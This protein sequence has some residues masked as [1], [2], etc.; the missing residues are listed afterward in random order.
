MVRSTRLTNYPRCVDFYRFRIVPGEKSP[1]KVTGSGYNSFSAPLDLVEASSPEYLVEFFQGLTIADI[2]IANG[3]P[4]L[5]DNPERTLEVKLELAEVMPQL[6]FFDGQFYSKS[7][8]DDGNIEYLEGIIDRKGYIVGE[9][10]AWRYAQ[11]V[12]FKLPRGKFKFL[13][14][15]KGKG[16]RT[17]KPQVIHAPILDYFKP[18][19]DKK[20]RLSTSGSALN[21]PLFM[22][23]EIRT[24]IR[25]A[26]KRLL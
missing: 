22:L 10:G 18:E 6:I 12:G 9:L 25:K 5:R 2:V 19:Y 1:H 4:D 7:V 20:H 14:E 3:G 11:Q 13:I 26:K 15:G 24:A 17:S 21:R 8:D 16:I 23:P